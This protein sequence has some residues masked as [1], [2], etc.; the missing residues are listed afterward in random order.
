[1]CKC[2]PV[3]FIFKQRWIPYH[4]F[5]KAPVKITT[6][7]PYQHMKT[8]T[9]NICVY[10]NWCFIRHIIMCLIIWRSQ[11]KCL[12]S[13]SCRFKYRVYVNSYI[14]PCQCMKAFQNLSSCTLISLVVYLCCCLSLNFL[15]LLLHDLFFLL[16]ITSV[17]KMSFLDW[18]GLR[19]L[20]FKR[21]FWSGTS[22]Y[23][24][25]SIKFLKMAEWFV[26]VW[27]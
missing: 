20:K 16:K 12:F 1:M 5:I 3:F 25:Y 13:L 17:F 7:R 26:A 23:N 9:L 10:W 19:L 21:F 24:P 27:M 6:H 22:I 14:F 15:F 8:L 11:N 4:V 18:S 2:L